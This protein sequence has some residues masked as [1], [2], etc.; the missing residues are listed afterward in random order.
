VLKKDVSARNHVRTVDHVVRGGITRDSIECRN[1][2]DEKLVQSGTVRF[3]LR[4]SAPDSGEGV[5]KD[6]GVNSE[7]P[8]VIR[9]LKMSISRCGAV[10]HVG[11]LGLRT[12]ITG[13][14]Y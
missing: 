12:V 1:I 5:S 11:T 14:K 13:D 10:R 3:R 7:I 2:L 6:N 8:K 4:T 9:F